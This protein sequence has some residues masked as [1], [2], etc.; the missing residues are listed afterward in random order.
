MH[1]GHDQNDFKTTI[2]G[3]NIP[4]GDCP[5]IDGICL[6]EGSRNKSGAIAQAPPKRGLCGVISCCIVCWS[7]KTSSSE[8]RFLEILRM[9]K[10]CTQGQM[11]KR[12]ASPCASAAQLMKG[13]RIPLICEY[14]LNNVKR[15][16]CELLGKIYFTETRID[17]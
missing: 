16:A 14:V 17:S 2:G 6:L 8:D 15:Y 10:S 9:W 11:I 13:E 4:L 5:K 7:P 3:Y 1:L 12:F